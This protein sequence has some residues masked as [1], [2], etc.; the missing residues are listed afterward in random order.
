VTHGFGIFCWAL[1]MVSGLG[2]ILLTQPALFDTVRYLG[3]AFLFYLGCRAVLSGPMD[4]S[5]TA[6]DAHIAGRR[7][8]WEGFVL[9]LSNPKVAVFFAALFS[10]FIRPEAT[11]AEQLMV[12]STAG[13]ID[14]MW[15]IIVAATLSN[16]MILERVKSRAALLNRCFGA[17][18]IVLSL[19]VLVSR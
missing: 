8:G 12:A 19:A 5:L 7:A 13:A 6:V 15:Y 10:Q 2:A 3:A 16:Q 4:T 18:L 9:A 1:L 14:T 17:I 11:L